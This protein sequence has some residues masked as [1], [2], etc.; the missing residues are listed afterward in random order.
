M[1]VSWK[2]YIIMSI[3]IMGVVRVSVM[4]VCQV[5]EG[6]GEREDKEIVGDT[7]GDRFDCFE[8]RDCENSSGYLEDP[9]NV[10]A[11]LTRLPTSTHKGH[12]CPNRSVNV[13]YSVMSLLTCLVLLAILIIVHQRYVISSTVSVRCLFPRCPLHISNGRGNPSSM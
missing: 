2:W 3:F 12:V 4:C 6:G 5:R 1:S 9:A 13:F 7:I 8:I 11:R 10:A